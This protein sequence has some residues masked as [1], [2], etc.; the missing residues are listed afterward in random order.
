MQ[1]QKKLK[2]RGLINKN[3]KVYTGIYRGYNMD[4]IQ[5]NIL[6][7]I[8]MYPEKHY[9][10]FDGLNGKHFTNTY[11]TIYEE[12]QR[13]YNL[14]KTIDPTIIVSNIGQEYFQ[15]VLNLSD[16][17]FMTQSKTE[18]YIKILQDEYNKKYAL[19]ETKNLLLDIEQDKLSGE[20]I[21]TKYLEISKLFNKEEYKVKSVDMLQGFT[22]LLEDLETK[23]EY[24][25]TGFLKLDKNVLIDKGDFIVI[26]GKPSSGKTTFA[27]NVMVNMAEKYKIDFFSLE[28]STRKIFQ[29]IA[30]SGARINIGKILH[31]NLFEADYSKLLN[32]ASEYN[33]YKLKVIEA[34]GKSVEEIASMALQDKAD[35]IFI[36]Y[37]QLIKE[38]GTS[39]FERVSEI[40]KKLHTFA[41]KEKIV[42][43]ALSQLKRT[44]N[45]EPTM[46]DLRESGQIEQDADVVILI[47]NP[48]SNPENED[49]DNQERMLLIAKNKTGQVGRIKYKFYG[50]TQLFS[51]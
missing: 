3:L 21:Q 2:T 20:E 1:Q 15:T 16:A 18:E 44:D 26:G 35:I 29:K 45:K 40:S 22:E 10:I 28:T 42:V 50:G 5:K 6:S 12:C 32:L 43:I 33:D 37:L 30:A 31:S 25:K 24:Y 51:E 49:L 8:L 4:E 34:S 36:D 47:H 19:F 14:D 39:S 27:V 17:P 7:I 41:Q 9:L 23:R 11:R 13:L 38:K 46:S 48:N